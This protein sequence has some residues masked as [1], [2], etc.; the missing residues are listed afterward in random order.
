[1]NNRRFPS[2]SQWK[3]IFKV[4][5]EGEK[6]T[7]FILFAFFLSSLIFILSNLYLDQTKIAPTR[8][9]TYIEGV[10]GQ[11]R[12]INPIYAE[13]NDIDR[14]L[15]ELIF[16]GLMTYNENGELVG[17]LVKEYKILSEGKVYEFQLKDNIFWHNK[18]PITADDVI[19]TINT[20]KNS[21]YKSPMRVVWLGTE[22]EKV[23]EKTVRFHLKEPYSAFLENCTVKIIPKHIWEN[24]PPENFTLSPYNLQPVG[25]GPFK[26]ENLRQD[27]TG[28]IEYLTL[29][30]DKNYNPNPAF[31]SQIRFKFFEEEKDL[32]DSFNKKEIEGF[33]LAS[34]TSYNLL[35]NKDFNF[36]SFSLPRY[37]GLFFN[38][39]KEKVFEKKEVREA[40]NHAT[41]K[42]EIAKKIN[43]ILLPNKK[44]GTVQ[45]VDS[46]ILPNFFDYNPPQQTY[47]FNLKKA[48]DILDELGF[49]EKEG[50]CLSPQDTEAEC[51][52]SPREKVTEKQPAF[53]FKSTL[54][55]GSQGKEVTE[56]QKCLAEDP[57][58]YP[59]GR[60]TGYFGNLTKE[61]VINFQEKYKD[62][63]LAPSGLESGVDYVGKNTINKLNELCAPSSEETSTLRFILTTVDQKRLID[64]ANIL[65]EQW[66]KAGVLLEINPLKISELKQIIKDRNYELLLFGE[67]LGAIPDPF[68]FWHSTQKSDPGLNLARY[69][70]EKVDK[71][72]KEARETLDKDDRKKKYEELQ[73]LIIQ[74]APAVFLYSPDYLYLVSSKIKGIGGTKII[75]PAKRFSNIEKWYINTKRVW[76]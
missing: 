61:A 62:E 1:M 10:V 57:E 21:D 70:N 33:S 40:L 69:E 3:Q 32:I 28:F 15:T 18:E 47:E 66:K 75:N 38:P 13:A 4:L 67:A 29:E 19:F 56:L 34:S 41:D 68:P 65:K 14:D 25:S 59:D 35:K 48:K 60:I 55:T 51:E 58:I 5:N 54:R 53:Q 44:G 49:K 72:L 37:F 76:R 16:S 42:E 17:D 9:G 23:S 20:I 30:R 12:F 31:I 74:D 45:I 8:G 63:I 50:T 24:I 43:S 36:Y 52:W 71:L 64:T 39:Q 22:V 7:L 2:F 26:F 11:P 27:E 6:I 46:P 73:N